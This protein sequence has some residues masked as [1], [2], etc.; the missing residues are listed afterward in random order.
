MQYG[1][2]CKQSAEK[3]SDV[4]KLL[5]VQVLVSNYPLEISILEIFEPFVLNRGARSM[6]KQTKSTKREES[7][8]HTS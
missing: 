8:P 7:T 5:D 4:F 1:F 6:A 3:F 2:Q